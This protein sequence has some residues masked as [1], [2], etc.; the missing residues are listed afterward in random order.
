MVIKSF[1]FLVLTYKTSGYG[2]DD[3]ILNVE[4][5]VNHTCRTKLFKMKFLT[6]NFLVVGLSLK[7]T[8]G[9]KPKTTTVNDRDSGIYS[10]NL[11]DTESKD[12]HFTLITI[13]YIESQ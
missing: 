2:L 11:R 1:D 12:K 8:D 6:V 9:L 3:L 13:I 4:F 5:Y 7:S 10:S